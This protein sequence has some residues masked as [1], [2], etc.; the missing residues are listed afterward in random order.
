MKADGTTFGYARARTL[1]FD[2]P[3]YTI[4]STAN[5]TPQA[6]SGSDR[7]DRYLGGGS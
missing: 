2:D 3:V 1:V 6:R 4:S 7:R 5:L